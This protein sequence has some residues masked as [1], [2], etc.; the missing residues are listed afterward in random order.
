MRACIRG[1]AELAVTAEQ[2]R[3][4]KNP[5][6]VL[7]GERDPLRRMYVEPLRKLRPDIPV[8]VITGA[9]HLDCCLKP[10]FKTELKSF[11]EKEKAPQ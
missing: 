8:N 3:A 11:L 1:F 4:I 5:L 6:M 2:V 9:N 10:E 7:I